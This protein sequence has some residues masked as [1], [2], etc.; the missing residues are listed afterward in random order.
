MALPPT[1]SHDV[2]AGARKAGRK[3]VG[4]ASYVSR[5][6]AGW[7]FQMRLPGRLAFAGSSS[8]IRAALG[9][10]SRPPARGAT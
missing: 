5:T 2:P 1:V 10:R 8:T 3:N 7:R 6:D 4:T 9:P